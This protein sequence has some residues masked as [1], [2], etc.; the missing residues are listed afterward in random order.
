MI[1]RLV[2]IHSDRFREDAVHVAVSCLK[3]SAVVVHPTETVH[4]YGS[5]YDSL[6]AFK[7]ICMLKGRPQDKPMILLVPG[8]EWVNRLCRD[9]PGAA[10]KLI[11]SF[12]PGPLTIVL[13]AVEKLCPWQ[14]HTVALRQSAHPFT[15]RVLRELGLPIVSTSL[16]RSGD[17]VPSNPCEYLENLAGNKNLEPGCRIE[18]AVIDKALTGCETLPSTVVSLAGEKGI[19]LIR[20]GVLPISELKKKT[21]IRQIEP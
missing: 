19:H 17:R 1:D 6:E 5:R 15:L 18:L 4:G 7:R 9:V 12:W 20:Q 11:E 21:G 2:T 13:Q 3:S 14:A 10:W 8:P 16:N